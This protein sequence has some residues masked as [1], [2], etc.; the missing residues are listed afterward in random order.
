[1]QQLA[2]ADDPVSGGVTSVGPIACYERTFDLSALRTS[3]LKGLT[4]MQKKGGN[5][6]LLRTWRDIIL[7]FSGMTSTSAQV[8]QIFGYPFVSIPKSE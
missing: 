2:C 8:T 7:R 5:N 4:S 3:T 6:L 1:M